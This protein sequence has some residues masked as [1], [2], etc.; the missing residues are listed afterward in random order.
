MHEVAS[1]RLTSGTWI[2]DSERHY[3][4]ADDILGQIFVKKRTKKSIAKHLDLLLSLNPG[5][6]VVHREHGIALFHAVVKKTLGAPMTRGD[7]GGLVSE[8]NGITREYIEL[9]YAE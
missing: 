1:A 2:A 3:I 5:D 9:H 7:T 4:I 8:N 6:Y